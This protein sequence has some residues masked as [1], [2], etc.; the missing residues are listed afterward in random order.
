MQI[1]M[2]IKN[3]KKKTKHKFPLDSFRLN[4]GSTAKNKIHRKPKRHF[5]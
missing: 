3:I 5:L 2:N 4:Q 1:T